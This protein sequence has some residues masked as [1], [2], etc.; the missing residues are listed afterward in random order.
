MD[1][2]VKGDEP[3]EKV[4]YVC[5][6]FDDSSDQ[7]QCDLAERSQSAVEEFVNQRE[8]T[9][10]GSIEAFIHGESNGVFHCATCV[11]LSQQRVSPVPQA[12]CV[13][14][15]KK[16]SLGR[17]KQGLRCTNC[18]TTVTSQWR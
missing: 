11:D 7:L 9:K 14:K 4:T 6:F 13:T 1:F 12:G 2:N 5:T 10:C 16:S 18:D 3:E 17:V 8:C 15:P